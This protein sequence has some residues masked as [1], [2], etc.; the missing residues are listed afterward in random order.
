MGFELTSEVDHL[1]GGCHFEVEFDGDE[2]FEEVDVAVLHVPAIFAEVDGD[3]IGAAQ[4]GFVG[5]TDGVGLTEGIGAFIAGLA[6]GR[7]MIDVDTK[8]NHAQ[9]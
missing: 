9:Q 1:V 2:L 6:K 5:G 8:L 4:L 3:A 7:D